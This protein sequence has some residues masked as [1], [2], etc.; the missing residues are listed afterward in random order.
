MR[1]KVLG[2]AALPNKK[3]KHTHHFLVC[4]SQDALSEVN[5]ASHKKISQENLRNENNL[6]EASFDPGWAEWEESLGVGGEGGCG[7]Q[8]SGAEDKGVRRKEQQ[9]R[10]K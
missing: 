10:W 9:S 4:S 3:K 7:R 8:P 1:L 2:K 5:P 6:R